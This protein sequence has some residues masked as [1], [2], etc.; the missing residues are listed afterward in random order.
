M[1]VELSLNIAGEG[2]WSLQAFFTVPMILADLH[3]DKIMPFLSG[4][5]REFEAKIMEIKVT[6]INV[7]IH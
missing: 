1:F 6:E 2:I 4:V 5:Y 3:R 7:P